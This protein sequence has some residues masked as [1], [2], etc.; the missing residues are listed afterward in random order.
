VEYIKSLENDLDY[1]RKMEAYMRSLE[2]LVAVTDDE[3]KTLTEN[4]KS[5]KQ[6]YTY[7][8]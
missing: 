3:I 8:V 7:N 6:L 2:H 5:L 4:L 1:Q